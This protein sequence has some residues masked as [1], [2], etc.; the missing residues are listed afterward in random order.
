MHVNSF[1][2]NMDTDGYAKE[3]Y[4]FLGISS[5][6]Y[7]QYELQQLYGQFHTNTDVNRLVS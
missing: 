1:K 4:R 2:I 6:K 7:I 3:W 5:R